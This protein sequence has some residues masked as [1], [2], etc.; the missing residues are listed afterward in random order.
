MVMGEI[1]TTPIE[2]DILMNICPTCVKKN[3][4][5]DCNDCTNRSI[6]GICKNPVENCWYS[7]EHHN[8]IAK[9]LLS[10]HIKGLYFSE[11]RCDKCN[12]SVPIENGRWVSDT[13]Q[14]ICYS[15]YPDKD[16]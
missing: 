10:A 4:C 15:C 3:I 13:G 1:M 2:K 12:I 5:V 9:R 7:C 8:R 14:W 16:Y 6:P 11:H